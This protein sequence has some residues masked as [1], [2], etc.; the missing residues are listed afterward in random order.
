[1]QAM[2]WDDVRY[3]LALQRCGSLAAAARALRVDQTTVGRRLSA[4]EES[5]GT[6]L[7]ERRATGHRLTVAGLR[8]CALGESMESAVE[9][10]ERE[11]VG[12]DV[13]IEGT[14]RITAP[15]GIVPS[16]ASALMTLQTTHPRLQFELLVDT[17]SLDLTRREADIA[18]RMT[19]PSQASLVARRV[20]QLPWALFAAESYL[21]RRGTPTG[22]FRGHEVVGYGA[23]LLQSLGAAW[24]AKHAASARVTV[25]VNNVQAALDCAAEGMGV[26]AA[27]VFMAARD[28]RLSRLAKPREIGANSV[29][30]VADRDVTKIPRVRATLDGI[31]RALAEG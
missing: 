1:M 27:P 23:P 22:D 30:L 4:L 15:G 2:H 25:R 17:A 7:F 26:A 9:R 29:F 14:V 20:V 16:L 8:A 31:A 21:H 18:V 12:R 3:L 5:L 10:L 6:R 19:R 13:G 28:A 24:F 11:L